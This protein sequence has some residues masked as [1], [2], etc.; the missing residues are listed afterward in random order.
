MAGNS[1]DKQ[2]AKQQQEVNKI[3]SPPQKLGAVGWRLGLLVEGNEDLWGA[4]GLEGG[5]QG[6]QGHHGPRDPEPRPRH[7]L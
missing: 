2:Q 1:G 5:L 4:L 7:Q 6:R 3:K